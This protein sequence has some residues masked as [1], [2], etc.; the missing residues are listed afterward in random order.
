MS[1]GRGPGLGVEV[2]K[3][4]LSEAKRR[5]LQQHMRGLALQKRNDSI[6]PRPAGA[7]VPLS[8]EQRRVWLHASQQ[9][10]LP[11]YNEP[12][13]IQRLGGF[14]LGILEESVNEFLRRHEAWRTSFSPEGEPV[15]HDILSV[16][17]PL[18]DL[19]G[20]PP[21]EREAE[22]LRLATED[23]QTP[24]P[25]NAAPLFRA[26]VVRLKP[27]E[28]RLYLTVHHII[29][30]GVSISRILVPELSAI[31]AAFE[32]GNPFPL[33]RPALQ[34]GDYAVWQE[35]HA[36]SP[37]MK[38]H[39]EYWRQHLS[40]ELPVLRLPVDRPRP[41]ITSN[42]G[43]ME[44]F[45]V[46]DELVRS[47]QRL[48]REHGV[49]LYMALLAAFQAL[50]FRYSGHKDLIVGSVTDSRRRPEL[51]TAVGYFLD[52]FAIRTRPVAELRFSEYLAQTRVSVL[53]GLAAAEVPFDRVVQEINPKRDVLHHPIFQA[54]FSMR[55]P[56]PPLSTG[57]N[58]TQ[59]DVT[60]G[61]TK[62]ELYLELCERPDKM[63]ARFYYSTDMWDAPTIKRMSKHWLVLLESAC[64]NPET[65][66][67]ALAILTPQET[68]ALEGPGGWND[69][70]RDFPQAT[71]NALI[72]VQVRRK[73]HAIAA[74]FGNESWTYE[75]L[76]SRAEFLASRLR[77]IGVTH[78]SI[79]AIA[80]DRSLEMLAGL[81]AVLKVGAAYLP[82]DIRMP[83]ERIALCLR[84][85]KPSAILTQRSIAPQIESATSSL[86][87][88]DENHENE[89]AVG[90]NAPVNEPP[91]ITEDLADTAYVIYT[92]G[93]TG[94]PKAVEI[95]QRNLVNFLTAMQKSPG[96]G[97]ED[98][99]LAVTPISF[100]IAALELFLPI[101][102][103]GTVVIASGEEARDPYLLA[104]TIASSGCT[105]M[106][107]TPSRW[108]TLL[109]SGWRDA[110]LKSTP[111]SSRALRVLSGGEGL[112]RDLAN[113]LLA[114]GAELWNLYG[115]T[116]TTVYSLIHRVT[117]GT[118]GEAG[119]VSIGR[120]IAN[121]QAYILDERRQPLP[122]GVPGELF[123]GGVGLAKGYRDQ[124]Q[125][126]ADRFI[127]VESVKGS[128]LYRTGD[129][130]VRRIDGTIDVFGRTDNQVK[131]RGYRMELEA[132]EAAVLQHP[133]VAAAAA[134]AWPEFTGDLRLSVYV[135]AH[136]G[137]GA[138][139]LVE[140]RAFLATSLP[141]CMIPSDVIPLPVIPLTPHGKIDRARLPAPNARE[142][143][144]P[145]TMPR[146]SREVRLAAIWADLLGCKHIGLD[147]NFFDLGGHSLRVAILQQRI[148]SEFG[149]HIPI[150][151]L[152]YRPTVRQQA[153]LVQGISKNGP[154]LPPGVIAL[155][156]RGTGNS[157]FWVHY[158]NGK[159]AKALG[160]DM[161]FFV[162]SLAAEDFASLGEAPTLHSIAACQIQKILA[163]RPKGPYI[164]G[165]QCAGGALAYE[166]ASQLKAA[167]H[168][169]SLLVLVDVPNPSYPEIYDSLTS[170]LRY[171][172]YLL[173][174][175]AEVGLRMSF[176]Y[177]FE[178]LRNYFARVLRTTDARTEMRAAQETIEAAANAY[179]PKTYDGHVL[180]I[181]ALNQAPRRD[182][183]T[184]WQA[185]VP[186]NLHT[187]YVDAHH[188]DLFAA[189]Q[190]VRDVAEAIV[191]H[192]SAPDEKSLFCDATYPTKWF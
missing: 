42:R 77:A 94:E 133:R 139:N 107:A 78:G 30:D 22:A 72:E 31:Y 160:D 181:L 155:Q 111:N 106:Q 185:V 75:R 163:T 167:G 63:E 117:Q 123:L 23:A 29:F 70:A 135:V 32:R 53:G 47:V 24:I 172:R 171:V 127:K 161:P 129:V 43:S 121:T 113:R 102:S 91:Q 51:E 2:G 178:L 66:L 125:K 92:S 100:D 109:L 177:V 156:P 146:S 158:L 188:R 157:I 57:W 180:L 149:R 179:R 39:L 12:F 86:V 56:M 116:E 138:P 83:R 18:I 141:D 184:G 84:D 159:L 15:I 174:R 1:I 52:T 45:R 108:R 25:L 110:R 119:Q 7:V 152:F 154:M 182:F 132:V 148:A 68:A 142:T 97:P 137:S 105:V 189:P 186:H 5:L 118:D 54:F 41:P 89:D 76:N 14:D 124:P 26:R 144:P 168:E 9:P 27:D 98:V 147:D 58:I 90:P 79:V 103:G 134:R 85:A 3:A 46:P 20:L 34:Y 122:V 170:K 81:V 99:L 190:R 62:F 101:I 65:T 64:Q 169:V 55:P 93:T 4:G 131:V 40:G 49:T 74:A 16:S 173:S 145:Q 38:H 153:E 114:T 35:R 80:L 96:F 69:T 8:A 37:A 36:D 59:M 183:L 82:I 73:P 150:G 33:P 104:K 126:T 136:E 165:G 191:R 166:I 115:P 176:V 175:V 151:E 6:H 95:T 19:S 44:C 67:G 140:L 88:V 10:D 28:H 143:L 164:I 48:S 13:T 60:V 162:V 71:L 87:F 61:T 128:L 187:Q 21:A 50:L 130:A 120:P 11:I 192:M 17:L 112:S